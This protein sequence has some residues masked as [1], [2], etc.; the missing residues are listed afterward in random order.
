MITHP[1]VIISHANR[2]SGSDRVYFLDDSGEL[3]NLPAEWTDMVAADPF[4]VMSAGRSAFRTTDL[5]EL[6]D[7]IHRLRDD[8]DPERDHVKKITP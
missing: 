5:L 3:A 2:G 8:P 7:L 1:R 4:V 6:A